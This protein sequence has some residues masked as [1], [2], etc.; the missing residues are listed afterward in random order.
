MSYLIGL[1]T[2]IL[3]LDCLLLCLLILVQL[4]KK[5]AGMGT[6][7]GGGATDALFGAGAGNALTKLTKW[8]AG[9]FLGLALLLSM[10]NSTAG[11][12][13]SNVREFLTDDGAAP[14][15]APAVGAPTPATSNVVAAP[16]I[17][18]VVPAFGGESV[19]NAVSNMIETIT[20]VTNAATT[21]AAIT[22]A[23]PAGTAAAGNLLQSLTNAVKKA[24]DTVSTDAAKAVDALKKEI[25][26]APAKK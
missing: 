25:P 2:F 9:V 26:K 10:L 12:K 5:E 20:V 16:A 11:K 21:N 23:K 13:T 19:S 18:N 7:F 1:L 6:A 17:T 24:A 4:P 3:F 22:N 15:V 14:A 8:A